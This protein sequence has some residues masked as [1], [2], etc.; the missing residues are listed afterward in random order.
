MHG[1]PPPYGN[2][3]GDAQSGIATVI[4]VI[5]ALLFVLAYSLIT[6]E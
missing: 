3:I 2:L 5:A 1:I 6:D 4:G